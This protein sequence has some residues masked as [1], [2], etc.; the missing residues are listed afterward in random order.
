M[1]VIIKSFKI[2][3]KNY[4]LLWHFQNPKSSLTIFTEI[5][6]IRIILVIIKIY[7][8]DLNLIKFN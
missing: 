1:F 2:H 6:T 4:N 7:C 5:N 8:L 3:K